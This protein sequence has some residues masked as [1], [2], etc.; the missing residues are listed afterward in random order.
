ML[1]GH[2]T[3]SGNTDYEEF[4]RAKV[5]YKVVCGDA[6]AVLKALP[7]ECVQ[8]CVT[9]PPYYGLRDY[10]APP[11]IWGGSGDCNHQWGADVRTPWANRVAGP[12]GRK[13]NGTAYALNQKETGPFCALCGAWKGCL[14]LEPHPSLYIHNLTTVFLEV[15][16]VLRK[17][18]L[19]FLNLGDSYAG[20]GRGMNSD[21]TVG[22]LASAKQRSHT[23]A[24]IDLHDKL[25]DSGAIG[26]YWVKPPAG[27]KRKE[28]MFMPHRVA[29]AL[30]DAGYYARSDMP[31]VKRSAMPESVTDR[32]SKSLEY[33][34]M[35]SKS[36]TYFCDME[37]VRCEGSGKMPGNKTHRGAEEYAK[38][39][40]S[41]R[42]KSGL[43]AHAERQRDRSLPTN[44]NG[45]TGS[46]DATE[47]GSRNFRNSDLW[48][49]SI[50]E[51]H[52]IVGL[53]DELVGLDVNPAGFKEA[54][55][56]T[57]SEKL[58][59]P[60]IR[61]GSCEGDIVLDPFNG[62]GTTGLVSLK[63]RRRY[64]GIELNP[65]YVKMTEK[66]LQDVQVKLF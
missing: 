41:H 25:V 8:C 58:I 7:D 13:K 51:P 38:G 48:Y 55:F 2:T 44:R 62:A 29:I 27:F 6:L 42:T 64:L 1:D 3:N 60:L 31:W 59:D 14:G 57:Y 39:D 11:S 63:H 52:G 17:G 33:F 54:H 18:G 12:N 28:L 26:R 43:V 24:N 46:L 21:G 9:S 35:F 30:S 5:G 36:S 32:P 10:S 20:S 45:I 4:I 61:M 19:L 37:A 47:G 16:R 23:G 65:E 22:K 53:G 50:R 34:F 15:F 49:S 66:R 40:T 56:A